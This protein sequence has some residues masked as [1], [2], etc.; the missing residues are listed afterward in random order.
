MLSGTDC[1]KYRSCQTKELK[2]TWLDSSSQGFDKYCLILWNKIHLVLF[3]NRH[4]TRR[5]GVPLHRMPFY[6]LAGWFNAEAA[7]GPY[8]DKIQLT[9][10]KKWTST[11]AVSHTVCK[12]WRVGL[13]EPAFRSEFIRITP[14]FRICLLRGKNKGELNHIFTLHIAR[15]KV[16]G[17]KVTYPCYRPRSWERRRYP[18]GSPSPHR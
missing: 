11:H 2:T 17:A 5:V 9:I 8:E 15:S 16:Q 13:L 1:Q 14:D 7:Q 10:G 4:Q 6:P 3:R 18:W 12:H